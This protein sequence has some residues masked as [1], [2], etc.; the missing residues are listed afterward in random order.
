MRHVEFS[1]AACPLVFGKFKLNVDYI[2]KVCD[3]EQQDLYSKLYILPNPN[4]VCIN[5]KLHQNSSSHST[6]QQRTRTGQT[7]KQRDVLKGAGDAIYQ[8]CH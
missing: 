4:L 1:S 7:D 3:H 8:N 6:V 5:T 2:P